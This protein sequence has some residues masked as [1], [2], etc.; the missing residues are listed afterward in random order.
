MHLR[1]AANRASESHHFLWITQ[2][3]QSIKG[4]P[5]CVEGVSPPK[6]FG[7]NIVS[8]GQFDHSTNG[9]TGNDSGTIRSRF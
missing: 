6:G 2:L 1:I 5:H 9:A 3:L 8:P 7:D 4:R